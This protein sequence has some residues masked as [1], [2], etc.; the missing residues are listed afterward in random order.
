[1]KAAMPRSSSIDHSGDLVDKINYALILFW[2]RPA[3]RGTRSVPKGLI[4]FFI[5]EPSNISATGIQCSII[6][7]IRCC[8]G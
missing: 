1:M 3:R 5:D 2:Q 7:V 4:E 8:A 6:R